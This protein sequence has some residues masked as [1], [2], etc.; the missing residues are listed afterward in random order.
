MVNGSVVIQAVASKTIVDNDQL[1]VPTSVKDT[2]N[3]IENSFMIEIDH[4]NALLEFLNVH[5]SDD[6]L[7][8]LNITKFNPT[9]T[10]DDIELIGASVILNVTIAN[11]IYANEFVYAPISVKEMTDNVERAVVDNVVEN[12]AIDIIPIKSTEVIAFIDALVTGLN[13]SNIRSIDNTVLNTMGDL[14]AEKE[15]AI[16]ESKILNA[17]ITNN[18][19]ISEEGLII[20]A[21]TDT[22]YEVNAENENTYVFMLTDTELISLIEAIKVFSSDS[23]EQS[24]EVDL[25][26][27]NLTNIAS[28]NGEDFDK[29]LE[30]NVIRLVVTQVLINKYGTAA[31]GIIDQVS[32]YNIQINDTEPVITDVNS[33][34]KEQISSKIKMARA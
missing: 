19:S 4:I 26:F 2:T 5:V 25:S 9:L 1:I 10:A 20:Y 23:E 7:N 15:K 30:S 33:I 13:V 8:T 31:L 29:A 3:T 34:S 18:L 32:A 11:E 17:T 27:D 22:I 21:L 14:T 24:F 6:G 28:S 16:T 12:E